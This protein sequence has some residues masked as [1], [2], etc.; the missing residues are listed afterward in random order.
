MRPSHRPAGILGF[1]LV[2]AGQIVSVLASS[3]TSFALTLWA[4]QTTGSATALG[5]I[6][7]SFLIPYLV[8]API[9]GVMV[10][11]Y[12]RKLM[13]MVSDIAAAAGTVAILILHATGGLEI[14]HLYLTAVLIGL[15]N[16]FQWPSY[17]AAIS[18][19]VPK[20]HLQRANG[21]MT[22][23]ES[24]PG[25]VAPILAGALYPIVGLAGILI[26]DIA[27]FAVA[28]GVLAFVRI[29]TP[30]RSADGTAAQGRFLREAVYGFG[31]IFQRKGLLKLLVFFTVLNC[32]NGV[33]ALASPFVLARTGNQ[34]ATL[35]AVMSACAIG[36]VASGLL[37][38]VWGG[39]RRRMASIFVG[40]IIFGLVGITLFGLGRGLSIWI[41]AA[42]VGTMAVSLSN[43]AALAILQAKVSPD[44]QGR[45]FSARRL[46]SWSVTPITP[47]VYG[48]L[49]DYVAEPAMAAGTGLARAFGWL[50]GTTPGSGMALLFTGAGLAYVLVALFVLFFV[51]DVR[52]L[53]SA[54]PDHD[55][56]CA[57]PPNA[58][59]GETGDTAYTPRLERSDR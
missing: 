7:M 59:R 58:E 33:W 12:N 13:M 15:G 41:P 56:A 19:M 29:P 14:W 8:L 22:L 32:F 6:S 2:W 45:V 26:L 43:G 37:L 30:A 40:E 17:S 53:E 54:W 46:F 42:A 16:T 48:V 28:I 34:S 18:T 25:V 44:I 39:F 52:R 36:G 31:Y 5:V 10:D 4:Y 47:V 11:R 27:T 1:T 51:R 23:V 21:M 24:G 49:A 50:V 35:G 38:A 9:A 20:E 3:A 57:A 55:A